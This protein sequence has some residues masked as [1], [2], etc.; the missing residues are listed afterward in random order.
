M[1][2]LTP[3]ELRAF[4]RAERVAAVHIED[5]V[6]AFDFREPV[7]QTVIEGG[8]ELFQY[9]RN[10]SFNAPTPRLG[11]WFCLRGATQGGLAIIGGGA[12]RRLHR[13]VVDLAVTAIE[14]TA[15]M[16][17]VD[18][19]WDGGGAGGSTQIYVT[20]RQLGRIDSAGAHDPW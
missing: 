15:A 17:P 1:K 2:V 12:G 10:P 3:D 18:W 4:L 14:G 8:Q 6:G 19:S 20:P 16:K 13:H 11:S 7:Y 5:V 9:L